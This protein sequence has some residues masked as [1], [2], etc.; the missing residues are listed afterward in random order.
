MAQVFRKD[1][2]CECSLLREAE[3]S[4]SSMVEVNSGK[5]PGHLGE[6][7]GVTAVICPVDSWGAGGLC[8]C[9]LV[10]TF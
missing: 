6:H 2:R 5:T 8:F 9:L 1:I 7:R 10:C 4:V 3:S